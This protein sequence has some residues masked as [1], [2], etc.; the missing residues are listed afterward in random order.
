MVQGLKEAVRPAMDLDYPRKDGSTL[1]QHLDNYVKQSG[2]WD[3]RLDPPDLP[4]E[5]LHLWGWFWDIVG[6][7]GEGGFWVALDAWARRTGNDLSP[8]EAEV[9]GQLHNE[10]QKAMGIKMREK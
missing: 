3:K 4:R 9:I 10:Y 1:R 8:W 2:I 7:M 5:L 6:G